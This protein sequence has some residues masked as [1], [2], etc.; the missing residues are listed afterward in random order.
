MDGSGESD[1]MLSE[2]LCFALYSASRAV[3][4][5]YRPLLEEIGLTYSQYLVM[6]VL[7]E[8]D[9]VDFG[10]LCGDLYLDSG[11]LSPVVKRLEANGL[12]TRHRRAAD[13]RT[14]EVR[15]TTQGRALRDEA[16]RVQ[17]QVE[18]ATGLSRDELVRMRDDLNALGARMRGDAAVAR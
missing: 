7:W 10:R 12:L 2:Q 9:T 18:E 6:L 5:C 17:R 4:G 3:V 11:S 14:V 1:L 8:H 13:E 16:V 15:C